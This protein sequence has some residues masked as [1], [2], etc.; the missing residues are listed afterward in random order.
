MGTELPE[1][2]NRPPCGAICRLKYFSKFSEQEKDD[3]FKRYWSLGNINAQ[4]SL[5]LNVLISK[6]IGLWEILMP[7]EV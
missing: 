4:R 3:F 1:R 5:S 2:K 7:R 6:D